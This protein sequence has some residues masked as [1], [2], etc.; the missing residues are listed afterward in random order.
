MD[1]L[2]DQ[3][4]ESNKSYQQQIIAYGGEPKIGH[5]NI[6]DGNAANGGKS[7]QKNLY[8]LKKEK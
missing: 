2:V 7:W 6:G 1:E 3:R 4:V 5:I 8:T